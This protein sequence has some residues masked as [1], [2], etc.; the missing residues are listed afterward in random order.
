MKNVSA[1]RIRL[2]PSDGPV[3]PA[4][5]HKPEATRCLD[6]LHPSVDHAAARAP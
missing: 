6:K 5:G 4:V 3:D 1:D 2:R